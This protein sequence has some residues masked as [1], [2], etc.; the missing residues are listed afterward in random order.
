MKSFYLTL[1]ALFFSSVIMAQYE[2]GSTTI[3]FNDP[4]RGGRQIETNIYYPAITAGADA[5]M[6]QGDFPVISFGHGFVMSTDAYQNIWEELIPQ[7]YIMAFPTTAGGFTAEHEDFGLD[8]ALCITRMQEENLDASSLFFGHVTDKAAIMGHSM[9]GGAAF[10][11]AT[12]NTTIQT[13]VG[14]AP[15]ETN[16]SAAA[17]AAQVNVPALVFHGSGDAVTPA[18]EHASLIYNGL[19]G[20][21]SNFI[22]ITG[23]A[24]CYYAGSSFTCDFGEGSP[25]GVSISREEQQQILYDYIT[26]WFDYKLKDSCTALSEFDTLLATDSRVTF[27]D[28]CLESA[29]SN[30]VTQVTDTLT[31]TETGATYQWVDCNNS[32]APISG[33]TAREFTATTNGNYAVEVTKGGCTVL[34]I[35]TEIANLSTPTFNID[36]V[37]TIFPNPTKGDFKV[38]INEPAALTIYDL[39]G[40]LVFDKTVS[41]GANLIQTKMSSG[42]YI[43]AIKTESGKYVNRKLIIE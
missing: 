41:S 8:L 9:G 33:E 21:C 23:G 2:V 37:I 22:S 40:K 43:I 30:V 25:A 13:V 3:T 6:A 29:P 14:L 38:K 24:H 42:A 11:A 20:V 26:K 16:P 19:T 12:N 10:L 28:D 36:T 39:M 18:N 1:A 27:Q 4:D 35:C 31:A 17:A 34:S 15:A 32:N 7:G 5:T